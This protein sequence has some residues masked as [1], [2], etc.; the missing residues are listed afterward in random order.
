MI[1]A[2]GVLFVSGS[3]YVFMG[4]YLLIYIFTT[5]LDHK[6]DSVS[7]L[8]LPFLFWSIVSLCSAQYIWG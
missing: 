8:G 4:F 2:W 6:K 5:K 1:I 7:K 3:L